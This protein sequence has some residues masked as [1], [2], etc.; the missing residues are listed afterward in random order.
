[1]GH[2]GGPRCIV[3]GNEQ[4]GLKLFVDGSV[5]LWSFPHV[6]TLFK[7][8]NK[9]DLVK[10]KCPRTYSIQSMVNVLKFRTLFAC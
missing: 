1:M 9:D 8:I 3:M 7:D 2:G 4:Q 6:L 10:L 5:C